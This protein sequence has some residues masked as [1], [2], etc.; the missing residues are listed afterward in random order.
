M[1][2]GTLIRQFAPESEGTVGEWRRYA[3]LSPTKREKIVG[4]RTVRVGTVGVEGC[5]SATAPR[6]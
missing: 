6:G 4:L 5:G 2:I 1:R 3:S